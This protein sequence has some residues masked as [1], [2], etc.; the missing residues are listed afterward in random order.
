MP[1][2]WRRA[3]KE[4]EPHEYKAEEEEEKEVPEFADMQARRLHPQ[5]SRGTTQRMRVARRHQ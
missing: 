1:P 4:P 3:L 5:V 2:L